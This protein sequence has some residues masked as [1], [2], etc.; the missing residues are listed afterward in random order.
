MIM[1]SVIPVGGR[2]SR[3]KIIIGSMPKVLTKFGGVEILIYPLLSLIR[4]GLVDKLVLIT[5]DC[6]HNHIKKFISKFKKKYEIT[7][8]YINIINASKSGT[9]KATYY[10][11]HQI[12]NPFFYTN[13]DIIFYPDI[14][15]RI[16]QEF[17]SYDKLIGV[18]TGS[19]EDIAP[20]H[21]HFIMN[22]EGYLKE[23]Q[24]YP[25]IKSSALCSLETAI[26]SPEIFN[27]LKMLPENSMTMEALNLALNDGR[28]VKVLV[29]DRFWYH[30]ATPKDMEKYYDHIKEIREIQNA[31][32][33]RVR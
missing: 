33:V 16:Y 2:G 9:A 14:L 18:V 30:L 10:I 22:K 13:G 17:V 7:N 19:K 32:G 23:V 28:Y 25:N 21:P 20:T 26:F 24:I 11:S 12:K 15:R 3:L 27:Y 4:V 29:Y 8:V 31:L 1:N 5:T 6:N